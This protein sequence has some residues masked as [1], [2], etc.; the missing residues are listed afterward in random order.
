MSLDHSDKL[1]IS[2]VLITDSLMLP[3]LRSVS[4]KN[5]VLI[6]KGF[7]WLQAAMVGKLIPSH[8]P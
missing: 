8:L 5:E 2:T 3:D 4:T 6:C 7:K 1:G